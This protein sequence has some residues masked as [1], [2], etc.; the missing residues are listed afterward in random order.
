MKT[1]TIGKRIIT[2]G[3][4]LIG[5]LLVVGGVAVSALS[6]L[7]KFA[8]AR[9]RDDAIPGITY[10]SE[11]A[12]DSLR[13]YICALV[14]G[15]TADAVGRDENIA[16][17]EAMVARVA[18]TLRLYENAITAPEDRHN[19]EE[20]KRRRE[21]YAAVRGAYFTLIKAGKTAEAA[22]F[23]RE[24]LDPLF[25]AYRDQMMMLLKWN[26][27]VAVAAATEMVSTARHAKV[28]ASLIAGVALLTA[29]T[30]GWITI[31]AINRTVR[32]VAASLGEGSEQVAS[33]ASQV[34][35]SSQS[36]AE[37]AS[38][39]AASLEE[40]SASL[41][42]ISSMTKR[43]AENA[44]QAKSTASAARTSTDNGARQIQT[45]Q[46][47]MQ[48]IK[49]ASTDI[50]KI[51]KTID[52][53]AFQTNILALNAAVEAARAGEAG[54]GFAVVAEEVRALAQ[55]CAAAARET[56]TKIEDSVA[57]SQHGVEI[58]A[59]VARSF[60]DI[61]HTIEA[62]DGLVAEIA[63]AANEQS[64][65][66]GQVT[67]A[68]SQMDKVTQSNASN[69]EETAAAAEELNGQSQMLKE[70]V[71]QLQALA[72]AT[73]GVAR[74]PIANDQHAA[75]RQTT[76][77]ATRTVPAAHRQPAGVS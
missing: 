65:G 74:H 73:R 14:A 28:A 54:M 69:A 62:L 19:L 37:G 12:T 71:A 30:L 18:E 75:G 49:T 8:G 50:T 34:S 29:I 51:L 5:L 21:A 45:M 36:L 6:Q 26:Q 4:I 33:A 1:W 39:Q 55:R 68:V 43:S 63:T 23:E 53:I 64:Q 59:E 48:A 15:G 42:E 40:T 9:L 46:G 22:T 44:R 25:A 2:G 57:K 41:E 20:L 10:C 31:R 7:E 47:A 13:I 67:T 52:E 38:E 3:A 77:A 32:T 58:G 72:G 11:M 60:A 35:S 76:S 24:K 27:N 61:Q 16:Q 66:I 17:S 70:A 56:A